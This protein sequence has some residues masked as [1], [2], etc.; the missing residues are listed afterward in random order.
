VSAPHAAAAPL[1]RDPVYD[2][3]TDPTV[4][5]HRASGEWWMFYTQRR[6][7]APGPGFAW[8]HGSDLG[9]AVSRDGGASWL[10]RGTARGLEFE[11]GRNTFWAPEVLWADGRYH[12]FVSYI[13]GV[14]D[15]WEGHGRTILHYT[16]GDLVDW[17]YQGPCE[18][19]SPRVIDAAVH[20]L[21]GGGWRMWFKD[22]EHSSHTY[23][24]D[25]P[26]LE[27]WGPARPAVTET[28]HEGPNVFALGGHYWMLVDEWRGQGVFRSADLETW[29]RDGLILDAPGRRPDDQDYGRHADVVVA[30]D[31]AYAFYFTHPG[32]A[33][34]Y[35]DES[36]AARR[37]SI[38]VAALRVED[39]HLRCDRDEPVVVTLPGDGS[40]A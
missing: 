28:E 3:A 23:C 11:W 4:V 6:A 39:G 19:G 38:Q 2:G 40:A 37:S 22:E 34:G 17:T 20:A 13:R 5:Y 30:G 9:I 14:P 10:Y 35:D 12:M 27:S 16:S 24:A 32:L 25:S 33:P 21:P 29:E 15:R 7:S 18:I 1:Y 26:D 31:T 8:V 36:Y